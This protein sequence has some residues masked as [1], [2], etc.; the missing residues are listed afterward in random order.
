MAKRTLPGRPNGDDDD[1]KTTSHSDETRTQDRV[2]AASPVQQRQDET[3]QHHR[4]LPKPISFS[5]P[6]SRARAPANSSAISNWNECGK[7][8]GD[9]PSNKCYQ[10]EQHRHQLH[11]ITCE[12]Y[13]TV[14]SSKSTS[15][16]TTH[17]RLVSYT[18]KKSRSNPTFV[19]QQSPTQEQSAAPDTRH[20]PQPQDDQERG[21]Q[22]VQFRQQEQNQQRCNDTD[23]G[24]TKRGTQHGT[25]HLPA[26]PSTR[27]HLHQPT[28]ERQERR[29]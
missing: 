1:T 19:P 3:R 9:D 20:R 7:R 13:N 22:Q 16:T 6:S 4:H 29:K 8:C 18:T 2:K 26:I 28:R 11:I 5:N 15:L 21:Q 17:P 12:H 24:N 14:R 27:C 23:K 10:P 25:T